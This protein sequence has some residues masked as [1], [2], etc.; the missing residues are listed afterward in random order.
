MIDMSALP[1]LFLATSFSS[2]CPGEIVERFVAVCH[3]LIVS[4]PPGAMFEITLQEC[5]LR[6]LVGSLNIKF[7]VWQNVREN[8]SSV[9]TDGEKKLATG[10]FNRRRAGEE[11]HLCT[12][13]APIAS[14][15][16]L[17]LIP[18][19]CRLLAWTCNNTAPSERNWYHSTTTF[20]SFSY[21]FTFFFSL[22]PQFLPCSLKL[23]FLL[24]YISHKQKNPHKLTTYKA[25][26]STSLCANNVH[27]V[28]NVRPHSTFSFC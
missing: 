22:T 27:N 7:S 11:K 17:V 24:L 6:C 21:I 8:K 15:H 14:I 12:W 19:L 25:L 23:T 28:H 10:F 4:I 13:A 1:C 2:N 20:F 26:I 3:H 16:T 5:L 9:K 18:P